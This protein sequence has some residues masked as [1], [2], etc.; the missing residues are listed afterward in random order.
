MMLYAPLHEKA[1]AEG[2]FTRIVQ[3]GMDAEIMLEFTTP[4]GIPCVIS[5]ITSAADAYPVSLYLYYGYESVMYELEVSAASPEE[6]AD[7]LED[8]KT[9][10]NTLQ[11]GYPAELR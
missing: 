5:K 8:L 3:D 6:E 2:T 4:S 10:S 9:F 11:N 7:I 1:A